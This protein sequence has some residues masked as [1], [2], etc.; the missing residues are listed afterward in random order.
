MTTGKK[1]DIIPV[2]LR[3][4][5]TKE[6]LGL[7]IINPRLSWKITSNKRGVSQSALQV[8]VSSNKENSQKNIADMW[9]SGK[10]ETDGSINIKYEG[11]ALQSRGKYFWKVTVWDRKNK[12]SQSDIQYF[13]MGLLDKDDWKAEWIT[14]PGKGSGV[15]RKEFGIDS[16]IK[17]ARAYVTGLGWYELRINGAKVGNKILDPAQTDYDKTI[18]YAT[19]DIKDFLVE[20]ANAIGVL[21][22]NGRFSNKKFEDTISFKN[23]G[24]SPILLIQ[25]EIILEDRTVFNLYSKDSWKAATGPII[26]DD[27]YDGETYD[28]NR[29][30]EGWDIPCFNDNSWSKAKNTTPPKGRMVS[31]AT[32]PPITVRQILNPKKITALNRNS[33]IIDFGQNFSGWVRIKARGKKGDKLILK[34]AEL[35]NDNGELNLSNLRC[36]KATDTYIFKGEGE[37]EYCPRF[38][39]HGFRYLKVEGLPYAPG[40]EDIKGE[41]INTSV[42]Q[43]GL[44]NCSNE[45]V[46]KIH[47]ISKWTLLSN[48]HSIPTDC[49]Q[50][51]ERLGWLG[52]IQLSSEMA[53]LNYEMES[54]FVKFLEDISDAQKEDGSIPNFTPPYFESYPADPAWGTALIILSWYLYLYY[55]DKKILE[56][57][58]LRIKMW[59]NFLKKSSNN[60]TVK[61]DLGDWCP[62]GSTRSGDTHPDFIASFYHYHD[63]FLFSKIANILGNNEDYQE[64]SERAVK[65]K[66]SFNNTWVKKD[67]IKSQTSA[68]L[69]LY[70]DILPDGKEKTVIEAM[71]KDIRNLHANHINTG[72]IG[73]RYIFEVLAK[74]GYS[75]LA[76]KM[77]IQK[78]YPGWGYMIDQGATTL[79]ERWE[80][81]D[82]N[83]MNSHNHHMFGSVDSFFYKIVAGINI[84]PENPGFRNTIIKP[85]PVGDLKYATARIDTIRGEV[86]SSWTFREDAFNLIVSIPSNSEA[87]IHLPVLHF[88]DIVILEGKKVIYRNKKTSGTSPYIKYFKKEKDRIVFSIK[89]GSYY[90]TVKG[91]NI[92]WSN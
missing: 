7:D 46:N 82:G 23:Y 4:E 25:V 31:S 61:G 34:H 3:I 86:T 36:A 60:Y 41:F 14:Y 55:D 16:N 69:V 70:M 20:G 91:N 48:F 85:Y 26:F 15:F 59:L 63:T 18:Y 92:F 40:P 73:T 66:D 2:D 68:S 81:L 80:Y 47:D 42:R 45:L 8:T 74:L 24:E 38:T 9:D 89:S 79:W 30:E 29:E 54:F 62:P 84:D 22:G 33:Y 56:D 44:F 51:D 72:I 57:N 71:I 53:I 78:S 52:D 64:F 65:I 35:L 21:L 83:S 32:L 88:E 90:F 76:Y 67:G 19:Y 43:S 58:Y 50:R 6:P 37:E 49:P 1:T 87:E 10:I 13:E 12:S 77:I 11:E 17:K 27:L 75:D 28:A 5:Y 39:Y